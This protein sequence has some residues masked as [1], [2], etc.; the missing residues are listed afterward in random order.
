MSV[1]HNIY[2][3]KYEESQEFQE[4][5]KYQTDFNFFDTCMT[6][7]INTFKWTKYPYKKL[8]QF[9]IEWFFQSAGRVAMYKD[10]NGELHIHPAYPNGALTDEG[11]FTAYTMY[12]PNGKSFYRSAEDIE[13]GFNNSFKIPYIYKVKQ[14]SDKMSYALRAV[15]T[16]LTKAC[17]PTVAL[18]ENPEQLKKFDRFTNPETAVQPFVS[19]LKEKLVSKEVET[20]DI[21]DATKIDIIGLWDVYVRYRNLFYTTFGINNVEI[22]KR[23]RL[24]EAEG[25]GND[26]ITRYSLLTDMDNCRKDWCKRCKEHFGVEMEYEINRDITTVFEL[27]ST[28]EEK[29]ELA[30]LDFTK[31]TNPAEPAKE[32]M[33]ESVDAEVTNDEV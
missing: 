16:S 9:M 7:V 17:M 20:I 15:D 11:D 6:S 33:N 8:P 2:T 31:G 30:N 21:Y 27:Q 10:D 25:A 24:T 23:E 26:E 32:G 28:N 13:I 14:F 1:F 5:K 29:I 3:K 12:T 18:F 19:M 22:Q 4:L